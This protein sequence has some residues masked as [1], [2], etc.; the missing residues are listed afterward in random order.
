MAKHPH[1]GRN[2][3]Y[4]IQTKG[5]KTQD[6]LTGLTCYEKDI[7]VQNG[8]RKNAADRGSVFKDYGPGLF[9]YPPNQ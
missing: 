4:S 9:G 6:D 7:I 3:P 1:Y 2:G 5:K 8:I